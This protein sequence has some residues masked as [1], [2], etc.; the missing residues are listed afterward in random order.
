MQQE[1]LFRSLRRCAWVMRASALFFAIAISAPVMAES[2]IGDYV[3]G[4]LAVTSDYVYR[5]VS[6]S[7]G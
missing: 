2:R 7:Y 1:G 6:L 3:G 5:G 4:S